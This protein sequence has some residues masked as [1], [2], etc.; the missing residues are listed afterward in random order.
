VGRDRAPKEF[1]EGTMITGL[2][3]IARE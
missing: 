3:G 1:K 2:M